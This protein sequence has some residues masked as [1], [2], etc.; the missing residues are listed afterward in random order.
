MAKMRKG[1]TKA[2]K[3]AA[4]SAHGRPSR[5]TPAG[6]PSRKAEPR[7]SRPR[8]EDCPRAAPAGDPRGRACR[9]RRTRLR[10]GPARRCRR[11]RRRRQGH[12]LS[13]LPQ[14]GGPVRGPHPRCHLA[15]PGARRRGGRGT[16]HG[17]SIKALET[18]FH[19]FETEVLGTDRKLL[20]RLI[21]SEGPRFPAHGRDLLSRGRDARPRRSCAASP[22]AP[23]RTARSR[24]PRRRAF[25]SWSSRRCWWPSS[26]TRCS[27]RSIRSMSAGLLSAHLRNCSRAKAGRAHH[28]SHAGAHARGIRRRRRRHR[29]CRLHLPL[30]AHTA[31]L[32]SKAG[33]RPTSSSSAPTRPGASRRLPC[34]RAT[35]SGKARRC[36]RSMPTCS[37]RPSPRTRPPWPTPR[38]PSTAPRSS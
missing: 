9:L 37:A 36:S 31:A 1:R 38:S 29:H 23:S 33:W 4:A 2:T 32:R 19:L 11:P 8:P 5:A 22:S 15:A 16:G 27:P 6:S 26:G 21:I 20:L 12:A 25:P 14:Q 17:P 28:E 34:A 18:F 35:R 10:R 30:Q 24:R 13:L 7:K 3:A